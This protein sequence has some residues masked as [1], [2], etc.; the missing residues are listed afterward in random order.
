MHTIIVY[1]YIRYQT[2]PDREC[3]RRTTET[4]P[5]VLTKS[6]V[7]TVICRQEHEL[8]E[9]IIETDSPRFSSIADTHPRFSSIADTHKRKKKVQ[10]IGFM[11]NV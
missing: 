9:I 7:R 5:I 4:R 10:I 6:L 1:I 3:W 2:R 8:L 11:E